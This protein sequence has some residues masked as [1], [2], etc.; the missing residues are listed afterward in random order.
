MTGDTVE[1]FQGTGKDPRA[2][3]S[4]L[5]QVPQGRGL[6][7]SDLVAVRKGCGDPGKTK[8]GFLRGVDVAASAWNVPVEDKLLKDLTAFMS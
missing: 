1:R 4:H 3:Q 7:D 2:V 6:Y 8:G 5:E